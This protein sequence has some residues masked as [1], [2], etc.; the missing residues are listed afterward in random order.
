MNSKTT[1]KMTI[2]S[3]PILMMIRLTKS[4]K[5]APEAEIDNG[6]RKLAAMRRRV[7]EKPEAAAVTVDAE[8]DSR[9]IES[10]NLEK[11]LAKNHLENPNELAKTPVSHVQHVTRNALPANQLP[12]VLRQPLN[13]P[14]F[15]HGKKPSGTLC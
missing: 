1:T 14:I 13:S 11:P 6:R 7:G 12:S 2:R 3:S 9:G 10:R 8:N 15:Q 4:K 5:F